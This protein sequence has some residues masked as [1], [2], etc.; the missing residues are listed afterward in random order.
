MKTPTQYNQNNYNFNAEILNLYG[1]LY[2][3]MCTL[4]Y[5]ICVILDTLI[6]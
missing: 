1:N 5:L 3:S 2:L 4:M 6:F